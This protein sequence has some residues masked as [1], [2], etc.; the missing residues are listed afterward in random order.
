MRRVHRCAYLSFGVRDPLGTKLADFLVPCVRARAKS[1]RALFLPFAE[2][3]KCALPLARQD[4]KRALSQG[5]RLS[6]GGSCAT[7]RRFRRA[8][9]ADRARARRR[10]AC[11]GQRSP[12]CDSRGDVRGFRRDGG[13]VFVGRVLT[14]RR[15]AF[16]FGLPVGR[17]F[18]R[19]FDLSRGF[20]SPP[21]SV[22]GFDFPV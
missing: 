22:S 14:S 1:S 19:D 12:A 6:S 2:T 15:A 9:V 10:H 11:T 17:G 13:A 3:H 4:K 21:L 18:P 20:D 8:A 16:H 7:A 5:C